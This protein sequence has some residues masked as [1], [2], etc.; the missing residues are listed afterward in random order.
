MSTISIKTIK[1]SLDKFNAHK[2]DASTF[3]AEIY[4]VI[5]SIIPNLKNIDKNDVRQEV[6]TQFLTKDD[7]KFD[8]EEMLVHYIRAIAGNMNKMEFKKLSKLISIDDEQ[9]ANKISNSVDVTKDVINN[10]SRKT[11]I[12]SHKNYAPTVEAKKSVIDLIKEKGDYSIQEL[13]TLLGINRNSLY[14]MIKRNH[15]HMNIQFKF[16]VIKP[17]NS[18]TVYDAL[19]KLIK[20][21]FGNMEQETFKQLPISRSHFYKQIGIGVSYTKAM[22]IIKALENIDCDIKFKMQLDKL[23]TTLKKPI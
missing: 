20:Q 8:N 22:Q 18:L 6:C 5:P 23:A 13:A 4:D 12:N 11:I 7:L 19:G 17:Y 2:I 14:N 15:M 9:I 3:I 1:K 10:L 21:I 16:Q